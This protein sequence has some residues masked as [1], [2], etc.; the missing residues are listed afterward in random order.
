[1]SAV[2]GLRRVGNLVLTI[3]RVVLGLRK[4]VVDG[5][6]DPVPTQKAQA[7]LESVVPRV[8]ARLELVDV[9]VV[10]EGRG[11]ARGRLVD[12]PEPEQMPSQRSH[13]AQ[14]KGGM[15]PD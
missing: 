13:V 10:R 12:V 1:M 15:V 7:R 8:R 4:R 11:C 6:R 5:R 3:T 9:L 14:L 2:V